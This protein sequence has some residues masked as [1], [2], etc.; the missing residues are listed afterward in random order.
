[1]KAPLNALLVED[2]EE[3]TRLLVRELKRGNYEVTYERVETAESFKRALARETWDIILCDFA[4]P[5]FSGQEALRIAKESGLDLPFIYVSGTI[6]EDVA[7]EAMKA[8]AHDYVMKNNLSRLVPAIER[9]LRDARERIQHR[10]AEEA[11]RVSEYKYRHLFE[12]MSDAAF[13]VEEKSGRIIDTNRQAEVLLG[14]SRTEILGLNQELLFPTGKAGCFFTEGIRESHDCETQ[15]VRM[16]GL[17]VP[18]NISA[19]RIHLYGSGCLL[20]LMC[21]ISARNRAQAER[22]QLAR[23]RL[24]ILESTIEGIYRGRRGLCARSSHT[25]S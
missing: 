17:V 14:R 23:N 22:E 1:M 20:A 19:S 7:V 3:D 18:V 25:R 13:L 4:F 6:G 9:E 24:L 16:D 8:G 12:S 15:V 21:D 2:S 5:R 11:M 10:L